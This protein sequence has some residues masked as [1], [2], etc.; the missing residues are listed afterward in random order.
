M[1]KIKIPFLVFAL[2]TAFFMI[3]IGIAVA[4][5]SILGILVAIAGVIATSG[6]AFSYKSKLK[7]NSNE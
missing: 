5:R 2:L 7:K 6:Y 1:K 3:L 4:E